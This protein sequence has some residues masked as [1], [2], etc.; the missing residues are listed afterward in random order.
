[1]SR[2]EMI[3][4]LG[5][6]LIMLDRV[7]CEGEKNHNAILFGMQ[8]VRSVYKALQEEGGDAHDDQA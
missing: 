5:N 4:A 6:A 3:L 8:K 7:S 2:D 1:M